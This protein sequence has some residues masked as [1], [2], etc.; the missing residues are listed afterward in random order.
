MKNKIEH[1]KIFFGN[2]VALL[3]MA[4]LSGCGSGGGGLLTPNEFNAHLNATTQIQLV[5]VRTPE[6]YAEGYIEGAVNI[7]FN[8]ADFD[9]QIQS[10]TQSM[11][12]YVYCRS[13]GRSAAAAKQMSEMGFTQVYDLE[14]GFLNW[15]ENNLQVIK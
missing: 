11:A 15:Q 2:M 13:G 9:V 6:E 5:D 12:V 3:A 7:N 4:V 10:Q 14:G 1:M 8:A